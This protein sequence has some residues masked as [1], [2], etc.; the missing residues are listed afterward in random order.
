MLP[1]SI[2]LGVCSLLIAVHAYSDE[3]AEQNGGRPEDFDAILDDSGN[4]SECKKTTV[5]QNCFKNYKNP[6]TGV[7]ECWYM[8]SLKILAHTH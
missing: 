4:I 5:E 6:S 2:F 1:K 3:C 8:N 7:L